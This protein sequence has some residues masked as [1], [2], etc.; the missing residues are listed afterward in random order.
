MEMGDAKTKRKVH[1][2]EVIRPDC[3]SAATCVV[4][5]PDVFE[6]DSSGIAV[7]MADALNVDDNTLF[8]AAQSCPTQ[9]ILLYDEYGVQIFPP[10]K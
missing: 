9:A 10:I 4:I 6:L 8:M 7:V 3:I 2:I 5:A 1:R